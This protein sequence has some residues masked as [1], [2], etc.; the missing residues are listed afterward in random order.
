ME[1]YNPDVPPSDHPN[2]FKNLNADTV[3]LYALYPFKGSF[4]QLFDGANIKYL[5]LSGGEI[6]SDV[7]Q[8]FTG[9]IGRLE[10]AKQASELSVQNFPVYP[11][12][13]LT[14]NAFYVD[15]F[16]SQHPPNYNNLGELRVH[17]N[18]R[19]PANA[20]QNYPNIHTLQISTEQDIDP[21]AF[22]GLNNLEKLI[23]K[24]TKLPVDAL[25]NLPNLKEY[26]TNIE[27]L[28]EK[29]QCQLLEKLASG[30]LAVQAIPNGRECTCVSAYLESAL[31][32]TPCEAEN[33]DRSTCAAIKNNYNAQTRTFNAPPTIRRADGSD[34]LRPRE[35]KVYSSSS[36]IASQDQQKL[37]NGAPQQPP[38]EEPPRYDENQGQGQQ[39]PSGK[40][41]STHRESFIL[42]AVEAYQLYLAL[43][44]R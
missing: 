25:K 30:Q 44:R 38:R 11:A 20:F 4:Q 3:E 23:I 13:E 35:P 12:H 17:S 21:Q 19:I 26:E 24:D 31:G 22:N 29:S 39:Y 43:I 37:H 7:S 10:L 9:N 32:R 42:K 40:I 16:N 1:I 28:D 27:K 2:L 36:Q 41:R 34:A 33:C 15:D 6:R 14:I 5:R 8:S 18:N